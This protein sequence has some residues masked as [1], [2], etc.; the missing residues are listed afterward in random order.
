MEEFFRFR[1]GELLDLGG[2]LRSNAGQRLPPR[3]VEHRAGGAG[4]KLS[5]F[6]FAL[7]VGPHVVEHQQRLA[8]AQPL[9]CRGALLVGRERL[10]LNGHALDQLASDGV[11]RALATG[12]ED[13]G[14]EVFL[15]VPGELQCKSGLAGSGLAVEEKLAGLGEEGSMKLREV[16][17]AADEVL[18]AIF[19]QVN[20]RL[21][22]GKALRGFAALEPVDGF[23]M[24]AS[25]SAVASI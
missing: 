14:V 15:L 17:S 22:A 6:E 23:P 5:N 13:D 25:G 11:E 20:G 4:L 21:E 9:F 19:G 24:P 3:G 1:L 18:R 10:D 16:F 8:L 12:L 7:V 2:L